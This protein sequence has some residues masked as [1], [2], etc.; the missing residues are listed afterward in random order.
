VQEQGQIAGGAVRPTNRVVERGRAVGWVAPGLAA[1]SIK[2]RVRSA[3][4]VVADTTIPV[5]QSDTALSAALV[6]GNYTYEAHVYTANK[7]VGSGSGPL[8]VDTYSAELTRPARPLAS[9][10]GLPT[11][12]GFDLS[13]HGA[14]PIRTLIWPYLIV[15]LLL[16]TEWTFRRRWGLR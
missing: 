10:R 7:E 6:P 2:L 4:K 16:A 13:R 1:D 8:T 3:D 5:E 9:L 12:A 15:V 14:R 11:A